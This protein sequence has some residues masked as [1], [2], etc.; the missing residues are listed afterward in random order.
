LSVT[1]SNARRIVFVVLVDALTVLL[2]GDLLER[3]CAPSRAQD[4]KT[5]EQTT[6]KG[7]AE[8]V[9]RFALVGRTFVV[10]NVMKAMQ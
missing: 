4:A 9:R 7:S 8:F 3:I 1:L 10:R 2:P 5:K 6:S